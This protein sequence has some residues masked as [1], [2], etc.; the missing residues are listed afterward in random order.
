MGFSLFANASRPALRS[1][2]PHIQWK[3]GSL[4][5]G[6]LLPERETDRSPPSSKGKVVPVLN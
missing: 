4:T 6:V 3:P 2:Q 1:T 5:P